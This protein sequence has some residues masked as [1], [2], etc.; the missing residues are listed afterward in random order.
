MGTWGSGLYSSDIIQDLRPLVQTALK[1]PLPI[2][3]IVMLIVAQEPQL[4]QNPDDDDY[5][6]FWLVLADLIWKSGDRSVPVFTKANALIEGGHDL[7]RCKSLGMCDSDLKKRAKGLNT[8]KERLATVNEGKVRKTLSRP[9]PQLF[10]VGDVL[11]FP[12]DTQGD[13]PN[14]YFT[15]SQLEQSFTPAAQRSCVIVEAGMT[16]GFIPWYRPLVQQ[17]R[18]GRPV[19]KWVIQNPGTASRSHIRKMAIEITDNV[20]LSSAWLAS[21]A[22]YWPPGDPFALSDISIANSL[23]MLE[24]RGLKHYQSSDWQA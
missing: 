22:Q 9:M 1:L 20:S 16:F 6:T 12:V 3:E 24:S 14:P 4:A 23:G 2:D 17:F 15:A 21:S 7:N 8:L 5:T 19:D 13:S 18:C 11:S 10:A